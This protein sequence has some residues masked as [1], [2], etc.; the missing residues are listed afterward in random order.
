M[1]HSTAQ[2]LN[3]W[4]WDSAWWKIT[5]P[6][7]G[8][9]LRLM[10]Q[11]FISPFASTRFELFHHCI[12]QAGFRCVC[13]IKQ[14]QLFIW[15]ALKSPCNG[16][17]NVILR[18]LCRWCTWKAR[19]RPMDRR[20]TLRSRWRRSFP[21]T[22]IFAFL[23]TMLC[24]E[25]KGETFAQLDSSCFTGYYFTEDEFPHKSPPP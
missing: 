24:C 6:L 10:A 25:G 13:N 1:L 7:L 8:M 4:E 12:T 22:L 20:L 23:S 19:E 17:Q 16:I 2:T 15:S 21:P 11:S 9:W 5:A 14:I 18:L 3:P